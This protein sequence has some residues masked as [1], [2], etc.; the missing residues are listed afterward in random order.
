M[1]DQLQAPS[2]KADRVSNSQRRQKN[3]GLMFDQ[4]K[5]HDMQSFSFSFADFFTNTSDVSDLHM[6][7][8]AILITSKFTEMLKSAS[9][10]ADS[11]SSL[12]EKWCRGGNS[13]QLWRIESKALL[14]EESHPKA[15]TVEV[16]RTAL[17]VPSQATSD[18]LAVFRSLKD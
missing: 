15:Q 1:R 18:S 4:K 7:M 13:D 14:E 16:R 3:I 17:F 2:H 12:N 9:Y 11:V 10:R 5:K 8:N 6:S